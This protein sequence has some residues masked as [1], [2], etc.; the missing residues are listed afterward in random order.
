MCCVTVAYLGML[1]RCLLKDVPVPKYRIGV[2]GRV[3]ILWVLMIYIYFSTRY[4][5]CM[6]KMVPVVIGQLVSIGGLSLMLLSWPA[7]DFNGLQIVN[8]LVVVNGFGVLCYFQS[9]SV[10][11]FIPILLFS[12]LLVTSEC[13]PNR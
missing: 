13:S 2:E 4:C 3:G 10:F 8:I 9:F 6:D 11:I 1:I 12:S 7:E 5:H